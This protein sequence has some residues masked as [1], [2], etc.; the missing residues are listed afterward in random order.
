MD[1]EYR[2]SDR[3]QPEGRKRRIRKRALIPLILLAVLVGTILYVYFSYQSG[4]DIA[5]ENGVEQE[6]MEFNGADDNDGKKNILLLGADRE[7]DGA[8]RTDVIML[9]QYDY[10]N[11]EMKMVSLMRDIYVEIPGF[12]SYKINSVYSL[13]G[14]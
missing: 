2:R 4:L 9:A 12:Q 1:N 13:G 5:R 10:M 11:K 8:Q 3:P 6:E 14:V 7:V